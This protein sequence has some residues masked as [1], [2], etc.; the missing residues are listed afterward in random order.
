MKLLLLIITMIAIC[1]ASAQEPLSSGDKNVDSIVREGNVLALQLYGLLKGDKDN[2][3]VSPYAISASMGVPFA[4]A[5][6][7]TEAQMARVMRFR[8]VQTAV[9]AAFGWLN[10]RFY[11][12]SPYF[13]NTSLWLQKG[14]VK[15]EFRTTVENEYRT[16]LKLVDFI[17]RADSIRGEMNSWIKER[18]QGKITDLVDFKT[19]SSSARMV[20]LSGAYI[21]GRWEQTFDARNTR[22]A[23]F[24]RDRYLTVTVPTMFTTGNFNF[25]EEETFS[26]IEIPYEVKKPTSAK[27]SLIILLPHETYG[28]SKMENSVTMASLQL[29]L[30]SMQKQRIALSLPRFSLA[31]TFP[32]DQ[33]FTQLN[34]SGPF[35]DDADFFGIRDIPDLKLSL[36]LHKAVYSIDEWGSEGR[37]SYVST[38][39]GSNA[40]QP[41]RFSVDHPF[42][43]LVIDTG[44]G[45]ILMIGHVN[46]P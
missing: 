44:T 16:T 37:I 41:M 35:R 28:L 31:N 45:S 19:L 27:V 22:Q 25:L 15:P 43:F 39:R 32:L 18:T 17:T 29:W 21:K 11:D 12:D 14:T 23:A 20:L 4:G 13:L 42:M 3:V 8:P 36:V 5:Q 9:N 24:F 2:V 46:S 33:M 10:D 7:V 1:P 38:D 40:K 26:M 6:G 34:L 30:S